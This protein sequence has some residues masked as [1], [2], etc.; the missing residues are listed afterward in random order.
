MYPSSV[1][2]LAGQLQA[3]GLGW[4]G[5]MQDMGNDPTREAATCGHPAVGSAD[6]TQK[7]TAK[8]NYAARH[9]PFVYFHS[10]I[11]SPAC[12]Q[13]VVPLTALPHDLASEADTP[14]FSFITP[15]L[16][17]DG[18]DTPCADGRPRGLV[19]ADAFLRAWLPRI[20]SS[21]AFNDGG[22]VIVTFDEAETSDAGA[23]CGEGPGLSSP[24]PGIFGVGG[25][26]IGAVM[27]SPYIRP[28]TTSTLPYSHYSLLRSV[29]DMFGLG[30]LG[31]AGGIRPGRVRRRRV[32]AAR[33]ARPR[34]LRRCSRAPPRSEEPAGNDARAPLGC[35]SA[36]LPR[37]RRGRYRRGTLLAAASVTR[38]RGRP[39]LALRLNHFARVRVSWRRSAASGRLHACRVYRVSLPRH[40]GRVTIVARAGKGLERRLLRVR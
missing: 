10:I 23:C 20:T 1:Q 27:L 21:P 19:S 30:H 24:L 18:H 3:K 8:D 16:C 29:E 26:R 17:E 32:H 28:G 14:A 31:M 12:N 2:T 11:D 35:R 5:Y 37:P 15:S 39:A 40:A 6:G 38:H 25:G 34:V 4:K 33:S 13:R 36:A 9:D 7:A 22:L